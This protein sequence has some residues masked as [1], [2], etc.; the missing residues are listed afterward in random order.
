MN[1]ICGAAGIPFV[2]CRENE[3]RV[4]RRHRLVRKAVGA[5]IRGQYR[6]E[7]TAV[8]MVVQGFI[9]NKAAL[10]A[11]ETQQGCRQLLDFLRRVSQLGGK[12][13]F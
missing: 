3:H 5:D 7:L 10:S 12:P 1:P 2:T 11:Q 4:F 6:V 8:D 9:A 13:S